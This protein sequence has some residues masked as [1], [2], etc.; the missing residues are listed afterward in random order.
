MTRKLLPPLLVAL[1]GATALTAQALEPLERVEPAFWWAGMRDGRLQLMVHG[2]GIGAYRASV[3]YPG[4]VLESAVTLDNP[5]YLFLNLRLER[6]VRPG[7]LDLVFRRGGATLHRPYRLLAR[8]PGS[9]QRQGF[10]PADVILNLMPDRF[11]NGNPANDRVPGYPDVVDRNDPDKARHGGDLAGIDQHLDYI[12]AMGYTQLWPTPLLESNQPEYSYHGYAATDHYQIDPRHGSNEEYRALV[13]H[14]RQRGIGVIQ[15]IVLNHI[16]SRHW[17]MQDVPSRD[18]ISNHNRFVPTYHARTTAGDPYAAKVD[19]QN[20]T[21]GWFEQSMPD[22]NQTNPYLATYQIQ[23]TIWWIEYAGL[24]GVR[25]DTYGYSD[26][27]FLA[28]WS[29]R[30]MREYPRLNIV[31]EEWSDNPVV[32]SYWQRGKKQANGYVSYLP[33]VM[34]YPLHDTLRRALVAPD[35]L[36]SGLT[37]LYEALINDTLYP[38]PG[39]LVLFEGNH[40]VPRLYSIVNE[41]LALYKMAL[42]YVLTMRGIPQL[43]YG[44]EI[45]M[46]SAK[47]RDDGSFRHDFPGGWAGDAVNAFTGAGLDEHQREAQAFVKKLLNWRKHEPALHH[48]KLLHYA[49]QDGTYVYFRYDGRHTIM[50]AFNKNP[51]AAT[52][53]TRRFSEILPAKAHATD[54]IS[55][56]RYDLS[57]TLTI[58]PRTVLI[59]RVE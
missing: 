1:L 12:A 59:L 50:V 40:D 41:D 36:H 49:P 4:V 19:R 55:A 10:G 26:Q 17:W 29:R 23:N 33:S 5:N 2:E 3:R 15:D 28:E 58:A 20:Y 22:M 37:D 42:A 25:A 44:T 13:Q 38:A 35:S 52:L 21:A 18:W 56:T 43:Y 9:A 7:T 16:G 57:E 30:V 27:A 32:T 24:S 34:D 54:V 46:T 39:N 48:G 45:L 47:V 11:A 6:A 51:T 31:G 14:A 53:A 8:E